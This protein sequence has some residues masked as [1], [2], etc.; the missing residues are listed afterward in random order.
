MM[1]A[2]WRSIRGGRN[3]YSRVVLDGVETANAPHY[4]RGSG[5][6]DIARIF[7]TLAP[8]GKNANRSAIWFFID[9]II[10][11]ENTATILGNFAW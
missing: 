7:D 3:S 5:C 10:K 9:D 6:R 1:I 11:I 8:L 2:P 4:V